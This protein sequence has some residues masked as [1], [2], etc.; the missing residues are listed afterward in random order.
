MIMSITRAQYI[1][2]LIATPKNYTATNLADHL[3]T[4]S[5]DTIT[6]FLASEKVV[7][8]DLWEQV[9]PIIRDGSISAY[10]ES[11]RKCVN[12][13]ICRDAARCVPT[14]EYGFSTPHEMHPS[15][16]ASIVT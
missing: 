2:Y 14:A 8:K 7:S 4:V 3:E 9:K 12:D 13:G 5:H 16:I 6:D 1:E 10:V 15:E 11:L